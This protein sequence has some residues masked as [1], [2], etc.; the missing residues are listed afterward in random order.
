MVFHIIEGVRTPV[1]PYFF[2]TNR[3]VLVGS[4][5]PRA[6]Y[7]TPA[8]SV[9]TACEVSPIVAKKADMSGAEPDV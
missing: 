8:G 3:Q 4:L 5:Y 1:C 9:Y 6:G 2:G 7:G